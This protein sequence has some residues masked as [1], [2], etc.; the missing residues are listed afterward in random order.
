MIDTNEMVAT[1][2][3]V[4]SR[5]DELGIRYMVT[6][7]F[8]MSIY[9]TART[10]MDIDIIVEIGSTKADRF[11]AK[12]SPD[13]YVSAASVRRAEQHCSM[14]N[15][16]SNLTGVKVDCILRKRDKLESEKFDRRRRATLG[17]IEFWVI[18]KNDLILSK[19]RWAKDSHSELQFR[20]IRNLVESG[21]DERVILDQVK[22]ERL[23]EVWKAFE[24]WKTRIAK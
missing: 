3:D 4:V 12:F 1:L 22:S 7:S 16:L 19:L 14:F 18:A 24:K 13:Y 2:A 15:M 9:A 8:A 6:G 23:Q 17:A 11:E 20:D 5:L 21:V 10:T